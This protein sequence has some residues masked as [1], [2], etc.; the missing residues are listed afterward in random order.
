M[1]TL[2]RQSKARKDGVPERPLRGTG[3]GSRIEPPYLGMMAK[4]DGIIV[5]VVRN[6]VSRE[7][8]HHRPE[9]LRAVDE[10]L[11]DR[12]REFLAKE[13][14]GKDRASMGV[15]IYLGEVFIRNLGARW[16]FPTFLQVLRVLLSRDR[17]KGDKFWYILLDKEKVYVFRAAREAVEKTSKGFSL[18]EYYQRYAT[19]RSVQDHPPR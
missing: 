16:H 4:A 18:Y 14:D 19:A 11:D 9:D 13:K 7:I 2:R 3:R 12:F 1:G 15:G 10:L 17:F 8:S 5:D 6:S